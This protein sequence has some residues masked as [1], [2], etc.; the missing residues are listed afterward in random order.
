MSL[1]PLEPDKAHGYHIY[2][3]RRFIA[4]SKAQKLT[5]ESAE[6]NA[7]SKE[8]PTIQT[9]RCPEVTSTRRT[10]SEIISPRPSS[11][12]GNKTFVCDQTRKKVKGVEQKLVSAL[13]KDFE[14]SIRYFVRWMNDETLE[15]RLEGTDFA[16]K[17]V[18]YHN[19]CRLKYQSKAEARRR[20]PKL[21]EP[22]SSSSGI[23]HLQREV[24]KKAF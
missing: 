3:Y 9:I 20:S 18:K 8:S 16:A 5:M 17:K 7:P 4:L 11:G 1:L 10:R 21:S 23:W 22:S 24:Y 19:S 13:T 14:K 6:S 12:T 2:C 15:T